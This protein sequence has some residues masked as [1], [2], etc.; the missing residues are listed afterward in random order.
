MNIPL[1]L[2][3][4]RYLRPV[5]ITN[6]ITRRLPVRPRLPGSCVPAQFVFPATFPQ[7]EPSPLV[8][9]S[10]LRDYTLHYHHSISAAGATAWI[11]ENPPGSRPGWEPYPLS[12]RI[13]N[14][15]KQLQHPSE[16]IADSLALQAGYLSRTVEHHLL[17][18]HL[19][20]NAKALVFAGAFFQH[21]KWLSQGLS[22][23]EREVPEQ[24]L[25]DGAHFERSPMYH[26]LILE[27][28]LDL[29]N[30]AQACPGLLPD[31]FS[32]PASRMLCWIEQMTHPD[33]EIAFFND[34]AFGVAAPPAEL[35]AYA[36]RL[37]VGPRPV[38]L[39]ESG[40]IRLETEETVALFDAGPIGPDYQPGHAHADTLSFEL[41]HGGQRL[42]VNSGTSTYEKSPERHSQRATAAHNTVRIDGR[43]SS[44]VWAAF[45]VGRR[46]RPFDARRHSPAC[47]EA[48]HDGYKPIIHRRRLELSSD[49]LVVTDSIEG[50]GRHHVEIFF[51]LAPGVD[52]DIIRLDPAFNCTVENTTFH[53]NFDVSVPNRTVTG[54][55]VGELPARFVSE[56]V[57]HASQC[58]SS[59]SLVLAQTS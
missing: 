59:S 37:G 31:L 35:H 7:Y 1:V 18:N 33:G 39:G 38:P 10:R 50:S 32:E 53:P 22:I 15:I 58:A 47:A 51:H 6:R 26:A 40:Y 11:D 4:V 13:V 41:S 56:C 57:L 45:R 2:R 19:F 46:A 3:T 20:V 54:R 34:A 12:L 27:D 16:R 43:D 36:R 30:L 55:W 49:R 42:I 23:L 48:A 52:S 21:E 17:A 44:E 24:I 25:S 28:L 14:W 9:P 8:T 5:Q 29:V